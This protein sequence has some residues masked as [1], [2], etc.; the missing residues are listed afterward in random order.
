MVHKNMIRFGKSSD[1]LLQH[2]Q[3]FFEENESLLSEGLRVAG[4][5]TAQPRRAACKCCM[6]TI[7]PVAFTKHGIDYHICEFC[8][9][10]N[11]SHEDTDA[12]C[13]SLY[14]EDSGR[15]YARNYSSSD[16]QAYRRRVEDI[17]VPKAEFLK[18]GLIEHGIDPT[19]LRFADLGAGSGYFVAAMRQLGWQDAVGYEVSATQVQ[20]SNEMIEV[21]AVRQH[22]LEEIIS[23]AGEIDCDVI[24]MIG[25]LEH[26]QKP[27]EVLSAIRSN[28]RIRFLYLSV[29]LFSPCVFFELIFPRVFQRQLSAGHTHLFT[30]SSID[31]VCREFGLTRIAEW[32]FGTDMVDLLR[33]VSVELADKGGENKMNERWIELFG[34]AVDDLQIAL[35]QQ[36]LS[37]EVHM[38]LEFKA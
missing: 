38:L 8:G 33:S 15:S 13:A 5:Y 12:F 32:W 19:H 29:P 6:T 4:I 25:V 16:H 2:K 28:S 22:G 14:T 34:P 27:R 1:A 35:D 18:D 24:S 37:S 11:G 21:A 7:G 9:H 26:L 36:K 3:S 30:E 20:L 23:L 31:W 10:L 17:Y